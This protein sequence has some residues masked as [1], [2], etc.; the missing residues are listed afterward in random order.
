M[1]N[2]NRGNYA[3]IVKVAICD[4]E[5]KVV[6]ELEGALIHIFE[7]FKIPHE[8]DVYFDDQEFYN[9]ITADVNYDLIFL[10]I[11]FA[12]DKIN[13]IEIGKII[14]NILHNH[15]V[16]IVFISW[17]MKYS[18]QLFD[19]QPLN[20]L[21]KPLN[22]KKIQEVIR[23]YLKIRES[24]SKEFA[25]Q[26]GH[27]HFKVQVKDIVYLESA[28]QKLILHLVD[29]RKEEFYGALKKAY[30]EQLERFDFLFIHAAY[31]VNYDYIAVLK[32]DEVVLT[33]KE[34]LPISHRRRNE[35][36]KA[37]HRIVKKRLL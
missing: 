23:N 34:T 22:D 30:E 7:D 9:K 3:M 17:H 32:Y 10:D 27:T 1:T 19:I 35:M 11:E 28:K 26:I 20:F 21:I 16:S 24:W 36:A 2:Q 29:G 15:T 14:R 8:I 5:I 13:G 6:A 25:Y 18:M 31:V 37:Y 33:N 4:D 12:K